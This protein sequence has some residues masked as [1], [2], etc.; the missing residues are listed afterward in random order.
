MVEKWQFLKLDFFFLPKL[1]NTH[2]KKKFVIYDYFDPIG[3][4]TRLAL[5][6]DRQNL[7][8]VKDICVVGKKMARNSCKMAKHKSCQFFFPNRLYMNEISP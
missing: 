1:K 8:F 3:I 6:N 7:N 4:Y 5:Q 2:V